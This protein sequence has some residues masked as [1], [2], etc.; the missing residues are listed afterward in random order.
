MGTDDALADDWALDKLGE[1][2]FFRKI[3]LPEKLE[4]LMSKNGTPDVWPR[5]STTRK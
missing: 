5:N 2:P 1:L 4:R 3:R